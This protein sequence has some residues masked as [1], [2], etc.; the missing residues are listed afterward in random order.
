MNAL[1][2]RVI[3]SVQLSAFILICLLF[4]SYYNIKR[5]DVR[6][7]WVKHSDEVLIQTERIQLMA[8]ENEILARDYMLTGNKSFAQYFL[9]TGTKTLKEL[10]VIKQLTSDNAFIKPMLDSLGF[11][12]SKRIEFAG[13]IIKLR[14]DNGLQPAI[15]LI[16]GGEGKI[17]E[18]KAAFYIQLIEQYENR[19]M[20][21]RKTASK[22]ALVIMNGS[23]IVTLIFIL[24]IFIRIIQQS[25]KEA[26]ERNCLVKELREH[27]ERNR[28]AEK[29][30]SLGTWSMNLNNQ[31]INASDEMCCIWGIDPFTGKNKIKHFIQKVHPDDLKM[32]SRKIKSTAIEKGIINFS[33]RL[34]DNGQIKYINAGITEVRDENEKLLTIT[35]YAQD[36]TEKTIAAIE[37]EEANKEMK[38]LFARIGEVVFSRNIKN[39]T[40]IHISD[41]CEQLLG[42]AA[43]EFTT[44]PELWITAI[45]PNDRHVV[46]TGN[47]QLEK[48]RQIVSQYRIIRKDGAV[49]WVENKIIPKMDDEGKLIRID[50]VI[51]DITEKRLAELER[52]KIIADLIQRNKTLEQFNYIVSHNLRAPVA[53]IIGLSQVLRLTDETNEQ[54]MVIENILTSVNNLDDKIRDL[55]IILQVRE[56]INEKKEIIDFN[57]IVKDVLISLQPVM[58]RKDLR[59]N[60]NFSQ[61]NHLFTIR[62]YFYSIFYNLLLNSINYRRE[63]VKTLISV[64]T[65]FTNNLLELLFTDNGKGID[66]DKNGSILFGLYRRFDDSVEGKGIGLFMVK[67]Q[68]EALGGTIHVKST[69]NG[70]TTFSIKMPVQGLETPKAV[71]ELINV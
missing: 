67:T 8:G 19:L 26:I 46:K 69:I 38:V 1:S 16:Q 18:Y 13:R 40:F 35:G 60:C 54:R 58:D 23:F 70:G 5:A 59:I 11:Y 61:L 29:L 32:V 66:L 14:K 28:E 55:N 22:K 4:V 7:K 2:K 6:E 68:V 34:I 50:A 64:K 30:A 41:T 62:N 65:I 47:T 71:K 37:L 44:D 43:E 36:I 10:D 9:K 57:E 48:G 49:R 25:K 31:T 51:K 3:Y 56:Q 52:E 17:Y 12:I 42:Y 15:V 45:H 33:F 39:E 53:N 21:I 20:T 27:D 24:V 63:D